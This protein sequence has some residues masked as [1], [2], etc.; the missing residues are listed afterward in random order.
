M[1]SDRT[2]A[3]AALVIL[4]AARDEAVKNPVVAS[5]DARIAAAGPQGGD[6]WDKGPSESPVKAEDFDAM[7]ADLSSALSS[8]SVGALPRL[9]KKILGGAKAFL[10]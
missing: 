4:R 10:T 6:D 7:I 9:A 1:A 2:I 5:D 8:S 3:D